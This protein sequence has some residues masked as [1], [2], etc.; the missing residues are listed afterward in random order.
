VAF[1]YYRIFF[2]GIST[3]SS[4]PFP[5]TEGPVAGE[6]L[7]PAGSVY[8][9]LRSLAL[10]VTASRLGLLVAEQEVYGV[11][12]DWHLSTGIASLAAYA[13]GDVSLYLSNGSAIIGGGKYEQIFATTKTFV[14]GA[15]KYLQYAEYSN[16]ELL[17]NKEEVLFYLL[18]EK[19]KFLIKE[20]AAIIGTHESPL[21]PFFVEANNLL[22]ELKIVSEKDKK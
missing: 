6:E 4:Y 1:F 3:I 16:S 13:T 8:S 5:K 7:S 21:L 11:V 20:L 10:N 18:T 19:G 22:T 15:A 17:P 14:S 9:E 12:I 2:N